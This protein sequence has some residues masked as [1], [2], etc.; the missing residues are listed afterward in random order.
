[1]NYSW[2]DRDRIFSLILG[3]YP[4]MA[5]GTSEAFASLFSDILLIIGKK[6]RLNTLSSAAVTIL[7]ISWG[8]AQIGFLLCVVVKIDKG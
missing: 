4:P 2:I 8:D 1:M 7:Q 6:I 5:E 3:T